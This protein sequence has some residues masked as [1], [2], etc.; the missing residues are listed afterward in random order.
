LAFASI[1]GVEADAAGAAILTQDGVGFYAPHPADMVRKALTLYAAFLNGRE[2]VQVSFPSLSALANLREQTVSAFH[3][4]LTKDQIGIIEEIAP[5]DADG[6]INLDAP[7]EIVRT[8]SYTK[9]AAQQAG[10]PL[11]NP[12]IGQ[13][14]EGKGIYL[15]VWEPKDRQGQSL[16]R[17]FAVYAAPEDLTDESGRKLAATFKDAAKR[18]TA[19]RNWHGHDGGSFA[20]DAALY[21]ALKDGTGIGKWFIPPRELLVGTDLNGAKVR[22]N[23]LYAHRNTGDFKDSFTTIDNGSDGNSGY[24]VWYWSCTERRDYRSSVWTARFSDG[25]GGW[26]RK[27]HYRLSCRPCRVEAL[28]I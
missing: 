19:V 3:L 25:D 14:I 28:T 9:T 23:N 10:E 13:T 4:D 22:D 12:Q 1:T 20:S 17:T 2:D 27:N 18:I 15:G 5:V 11:K 24:A 26:D 6:N 8:L 21:T 7:Q 16:S